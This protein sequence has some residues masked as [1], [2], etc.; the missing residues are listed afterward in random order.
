MER[1][2]ENWLIDDRCFAHTIKATGRYLTTPAPHSNNS[3]ASWSP[4][5]SQIE[6]R[7]LKMDMVCILCTPYSGGCMTRGCRERLKNPRI[8]T[9]QIAIKKV[10]ISRS[11]KI[12]Y[13]SAIEAIYNG[14]FLHRCPSFL[15]KYKYMLTFSILSSIK[16]N[17]AMT[18]EKTKC[19]AINVKIIWVQFKKHWSTETHNA[20]S[21]GLP[22]LHWHN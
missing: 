4:Q 14:S 20:L 3:R 11:S 2:E 12:R 5:E 17:F 8:M 15:I 6:K 7:V 1:M 18:Q 22:T 16:C 13:L 19:Q 9:T 10:Q 21:S